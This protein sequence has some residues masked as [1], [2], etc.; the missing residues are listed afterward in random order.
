AV[1]SSLYPA[2]TVLLARW[3]LKESLQRIQV[4][5]LFGAVAASALIALG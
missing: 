1:L 4:L 5:G 3:I 2:A